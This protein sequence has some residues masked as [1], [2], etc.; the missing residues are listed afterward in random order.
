ML[1]LPRFRYKKNNFKIKL[2]EYRTKRSKAECDLEDRINITLLM[3]NKKRRVLYGGEINEI[4]WRLLIKYYH[5]ILNSI[6][7][8]FLR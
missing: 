5:E 4:N 7:D 3:Y 2:K 6:K 1:L 8:V